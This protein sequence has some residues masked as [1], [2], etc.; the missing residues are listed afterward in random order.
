MFGAE[1][2]DRPVGPLPPFTLK[3]NVGKPLGVLGALLAFAAVL[4]ALVYLI[5]FLTSLKGH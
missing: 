4:V 3:D 2:S 5:Q 1:L